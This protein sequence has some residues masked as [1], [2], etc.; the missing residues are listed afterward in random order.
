MRK[1]M[2]VGLVVSLATLLIAGGLYAS[3]MAFKL[4]YTLLGDPDPNSLTG[5]S[6]IALPFNQ[7]TNLINANDLLLDI[8][9]TSI[10]QAIIRFER[11]SNGV[12]AYTGTAGAPFLLAPAEA[13]FVQLRPG[14]A[15]RQYIIVGSD[16][17][18][19]VVTFDGSGTNGSLNGTNFYAYPY[20]SIS[21][22]ASELLNELGGTAV[23][24]AVTKFEKSSNGVT[25]YT[26]TAGAPFAL[27]PGEGYFVQLR[28]GVPSLS[29]IPAHY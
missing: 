17:P 10:V 15:N 13:Y 22:D 8:G 24:Q 9:G 4:N 5:Q 14:Q 7:Q 12:T 2:V 26:G 3:N 23:V 18:A 1:K 25:A 29:F 28:P 11:T 16:D 27:L 6:T 19:F 21:N 20:H